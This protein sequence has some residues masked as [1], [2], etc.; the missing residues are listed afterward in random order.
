MTGSS[1]RQTSL[2]QRRNSEMRSGNFPSLPFGVSGDESRTIRLPGPPEIIVKLPNNDASADP[3]TRP[4]SF[5][6]ISIQ[7]AAFVRFIPNFSSTMSFASDDSERGC[8]VERR[9]RES[10]V[11]SESVM[12]E[13]AGDFGDSYCSNS[14][15]LNTGFSSSS[16]RTEC[17]RRLAL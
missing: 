3:C 1:G 9:R 2:F 12:V 14:R 6:K 17:R 13:K 8:G 10:E 16:T 4:H 15:P 7:E 5:S 11:T